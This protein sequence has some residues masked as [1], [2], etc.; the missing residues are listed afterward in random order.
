M[1]EQDRTTIELIYTG[2]RRT[3]SGATRY[4]YLSPEGESRIFAKR[5]YPCSVG[6]RIE[7]EATPDRAS[8]FPDRATYLGP[9]DRS[10]PRLIEWAAEDEF[11]DQDAK[12]KAAERKA[13]AE[14]PLED[15]LASL[16]RAAS[17]LNKPQRRALASRVLEALYL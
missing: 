16:S 9:L 10:D 12:R 3:L 6:G 1:T 2:R 7:I 17:G 15:L 5:L 8:V 13:L 11:A 14:D 4:A